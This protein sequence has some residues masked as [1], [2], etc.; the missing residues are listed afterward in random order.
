M[1]PT[2]EQVAGGHRDQ[3]GRSRQRLGGAVARARGP[4]LATA[5]CGAKMAA[6]LPKELVVIRSTTSA[7]LALVCLL[8]ASPV[9]AD[10][11]QPETPSSERRSS[12]ASR[13]GLELGLR[14]GFGMPFGNVYDGPNLSM[15]D[16]LTGTI[17]LRLDVGY[18]PVGAI[19]AGIYAELGLALVNNNSFPCSAGASCSA[20]QARIGIEAQYHLAPSKGFDPWFGLGFGYEGLNYKATGSSQGDFGRK[21]RGLELLSIQV[22]GD[23]QAGSRLAV[24]PFVSFSLGKYDYASEYRKTAVGMEQTSGFD[25]DHTAMHEWLLFGLRGVYAL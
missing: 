19:Y 20:S 6:T 10:D 24:G 23:I 3:L 15:R 7:S 16:A 1:P 9:R 5:R 4:L 18:R 12:D 22:G 21:V 25:I 17:P 13:T 8:A 11:V 14:T 2:S